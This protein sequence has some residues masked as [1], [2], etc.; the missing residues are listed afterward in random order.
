MPDNPSDEE[1]QR[2]VAEQA[3]VDREIADLQRQRR[4]ALIEVVLAENPNVQVV[5]REKGIYRTPV[6]DQAG[7]VRWVYG[8]VT[9]L[10]HIDA[11]SPSV[12]TLGADIA[13]RP[14]P[15]SG[16]TSRLLVGGSGA[17]S[18]VQP[19][20]GDIDFAEELQVKARSAEAAGAA[21]AETI[22]E[23]VRR[24]KRNPA[25]EFN[26]LKLR[27]PNPLPA[28]PVD[29]HT[30]EVEEEDFTWDLG[31]I[32]APG[33]KRALARQLAGM[34][35]RGWRVLTFW[36]AFIAG[37][38]FIEVTKVLNIQ[39]ISSQT[40]ETLFSTDFLGSEFQEGYLD[41]PPQIEPVMLGAYAALMRTKALDEA[42]GGRWLKASK[43]AF[44]FCRAIGNI[45][46]TRDFTPI[47][48]TDQAR[49]N[50]SVSEADGINLSLRWG[51][52]LMTA[53]AGAIVLRSVA[54]SIRSLPL[55]IP[56]RSP[57]DTAKD[58]EA[59]GPRLRNDPATGGL[60]K[61]IPLFDELSA[62]L[63]NR[64][65]PLINASLGDRVGPL[66]TKHIGEY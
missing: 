51:S 64:V 39:A 5:N 19:H 32:L 47:F 36:R 50:Q 12:F 31:R 48:A 28:A 49:V 16:V 22:I 30:H 33:S 52:R 21:L 59:F 3:R 7:L 53:E 8:S 13:A 45:D 44:N 23:F 41:E 26:R 56:Y 60:Q 43:R 34:G 10:W 38:R 57:E 58:L 17:Q 35:N 37:G 6:V 20:P 61:D 54:I 4:D 27:D 2:V 46:G 11:L 29:P 42:R 25:F 14:K 1:R 24:N 66:I 63:S 55:V 15:G 62:F 9:V 40:G 18:V 65:E